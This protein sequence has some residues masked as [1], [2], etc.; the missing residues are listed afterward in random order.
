MRILLIEDNP[1]YAIF[2]KRVFKKANQNYEID[3]VVDAKE[4]LKNIFSE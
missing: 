2:T 4:A 3:S 1:D